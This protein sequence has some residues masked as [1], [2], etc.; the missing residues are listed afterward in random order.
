M[1]KLFLKFLNS[2]SYAYYYRKNYKIY[3][4]FLYIKLFK[5]ISSGKLNTFP[6]PSLEVKKFTFKF[7]N[8]INAKYGVCVTNGSDSMRVGLI[9]FCS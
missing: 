4:I 6:Y 8:F 7:L 1:I 5:R 9:C 3:S 2:F